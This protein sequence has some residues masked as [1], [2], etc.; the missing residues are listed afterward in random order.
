VSLLADAFTVI[1][2]FLE[3]DRGPDQSGGFRVN[4]NLFFAMFGVGFL[5]GMVGHLVKSRTLVATGIALVFLATF[6]IPIA[7][8]AAN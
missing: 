4:P 5:L 3:P 6:L 8:Q 7:L 1:A 2:Q